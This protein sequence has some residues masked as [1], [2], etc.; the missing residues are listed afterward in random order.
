M[1]CIA[2]KSKNIL[3]ERYLEESP[4]FMLLHF[5]III[6]N[7]SVISLLHHNSKIISLVCFICYIIYYI[8][9]KKLSVCAFYW[10]K[11]SVRK[12]FKQ[13]FDLRNISHLQ[14]V[15]SSFIPAKKETLEQVFSCEFREI[16]KNTF[17]TEHL[18]TTASVGIFRHCFQNTYFNEQF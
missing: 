6:K 15:N 11:I 7:I 5:Y 17:F 18:P 3:L 12:R 8:I 14:K 2:S 9:I 13:I 10:K 4:L 1:I 16:S